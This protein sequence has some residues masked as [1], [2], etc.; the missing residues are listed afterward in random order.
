MRI[1]LK[2]I[3]GISFILIQEAENEQALMITP[4]GLV[5]KMDSK[6]SQSRLRSRM[7]RN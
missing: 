6:L 2:K 5:K 4:L 1:C 7:K 3:T